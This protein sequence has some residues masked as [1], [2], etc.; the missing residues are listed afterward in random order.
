M[1]DSLLRENME[2][3]DLQAQFIAKASSFLYDPK[4][5]KYFKL[6]QFQLQCNLY[7]FQ[8]SYF[9]YKKVWNSLSS[10]ASKHLATYWPLVVL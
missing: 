6:Q 3:H 9:Q 4:P 5:S 8:N 2:I 1:V 10:F 7:F